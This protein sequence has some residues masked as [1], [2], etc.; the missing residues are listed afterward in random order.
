MP[1]P[2]L[3]ELRERFSGQEA[4]FQSAL[5]VLRSGQLFDA[6]AV[7]SQLDAIQGAE[8]VCQITLAHRH[9]AAPN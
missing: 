7:D 6:R 1:L 4:A 2:T 3:T 9:V 5:Q 8:R